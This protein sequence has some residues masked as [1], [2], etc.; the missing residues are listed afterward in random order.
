MLIAQND[1]KGKKRL[2]NQKLVVKSS[3]NNQFLSGIE[4]NNFLVKRDSGKVEELTQQ[5]G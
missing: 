2:K 3:E 4:K 5:S 1:E